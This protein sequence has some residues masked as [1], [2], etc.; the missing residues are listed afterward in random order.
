MNDF[1][2]YFRRHDL[3]RLLDEAT[4]AARLVH[5]YEDQI[6]RLLSTYE[7]EA[8]SNRLARTLQEVSNAARLYDQ[9]Y[10][11]QVHRLAT[12]TLAALPAVTHILEESSLQSV[13]RDHAYRQRAVEMSRGLL[14]T[15]RNQATADL[16]SLPR[17]LAAEVGRLQD[18]ARVA[19][20]PAYLLAHQMVLDSIAR[21]AGAL[22]AE[23]LASQ[24][25]HHLAAV[26]LAGTT[27][28]REA[29]LEELVEWWS[30]LLSALR[31]SSSTVWALLSLLVTLLVFAYQEWGSD[32]M[33]LRLNQKILDSEQRIVSQIDTLRPTEPRQLLLVSR[34]LRLR[35]GPSVQ[36]RTI[37]VLNP[38]VVVGEIDRQGNWV[39]VECFDVGTGEQNTGWV[40]RRYLRSIPPSS[41]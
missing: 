35:G 5:R 13:L 41:Q 21:S 9:T 27:E 7:L 22:T 38:G 37:R 19:Y 2:D 28:D 31:P 20:P 1:S 10:M 30:S 3:R 23:S 39:F 11:D 6:N 17:R 15:Y 34:R 32:Q 14:Q 8:S 24:F 18:L 12:S 40:Y 25:A 16:V 29:L 36:E 33:E 26:E 4:A